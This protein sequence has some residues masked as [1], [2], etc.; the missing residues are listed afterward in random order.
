MPRVKPEPIGVVAPLHY[1]RR[2]KARNEPVTVDPSVGRRISPFPGWSASGQCYQGF[3]LGQRV[4]EKNNAGGGRRAIEQPPPPSARVRPFRARRLTYR[5]QQ[6]KRRHEF[7]TFGQHRGGTHDHRSRRQSQRAAASLAKRLGALSVFWRRLAWV[8]T[9]HRAEVAASKRKV[10][11][12]GTPPGSS[13]W[14]DADGDD[15]DVEELLG[16]GSAW[17]SCERCAATSSGV[18]DPGKMLPHAAV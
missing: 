17:T 14:I 12:L 4:G 9:H 3:C 2:L 5:R 10:D 6:M 16:V 11:L 1:G 18:T 7:Q 8:R 15:H 13:H